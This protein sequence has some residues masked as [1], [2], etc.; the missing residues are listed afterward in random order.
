MLGSS[1]EETEE[2]IIAH[3]REPEALTT[4]APELLQE[5]TE[6]SMLG[7]REGCLMTTVSKN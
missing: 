6:A 5:A 7:I 3:T 4:E 2:L 1:S